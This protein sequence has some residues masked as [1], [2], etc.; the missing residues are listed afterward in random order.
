MKTFVLGQKW[1][2]E[3]ASKDNVYWIGVST[4]GFMLLGAECKTLHELEAVARQLHEDLDR[5]IAEAREKLQPD[6]APQG[7]QTRVTEMRT[8]PKKS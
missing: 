2:D 4:P 8:P 3:L 1:P 5:V 7:F 6:P